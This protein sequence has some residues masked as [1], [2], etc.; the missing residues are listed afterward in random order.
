MSR[1]VRLKTPGGGLHASSTPGW[2]RST[3][4]YIITSVGGVWYRRARVWHWC[5]EVE[6]VDPFEG[7]QFLKVLSVASVMGL[8]S[9]G[10]LVASLYGVAVSC[11][12]SLQ[13]AIVVNRCSRSLHTVLDQHTGLPLNEMEWQI[14]PGCYLICC[15][16]TSSICINVVL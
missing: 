14:G 16:I 15:V 2:V 3:L 7:N 4:R 6:E 12:W 9:S 13:L 11:V 1:L 5:Q 10:F 8:F